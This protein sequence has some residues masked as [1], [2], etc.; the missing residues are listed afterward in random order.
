LE[1]RARRGVGLAEAGALLLTH[2]KVIAARLAAAGEELPVMGSCAA[3]ACTLCLPSA[4]DPDARRG[5][6]PDQAG[7]PEAFA[8]VDRGEADL[9]LVFHYPQGVPLLVQLSAQPLVRDPITV[10]L[11]ASGDVELSDPAGERSVAEC[12]RCRS[13][14]VCACRSPL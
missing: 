14:P 13:H 4:C 11:P 10:V 12:L 5:R 6:R 7:L 2:A 1:V 8:M 9:G 3:D